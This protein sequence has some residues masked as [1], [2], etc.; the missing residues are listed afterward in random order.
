M[1]VKKLLFASVGCVLVAAT[2]EPH[3]SPAAFDMTREIVIEG[4][5]VELEWKNPHIYLTLETTGAD[6]VVRRQEAE[7]APVGSVQTYGVTRAHL[8]PGTPIVLRANPSRREG[9]I[10]RAL[11]FA[12]SDGSVRMLDAIGSRS[13]STL[14][15]TV[16]AERLVSKWVLPPA[17]FLSRVLAP[18]PLTEAAQ[19]ARAQAM[20]VPDAETLCG[21]EIPPP[22]LGPTLY[23]IEVSD[24]AVVIR[25]D[26]EG[27]AGRRISLVE[28]AHPAD[29]QPS[30]KGHSIGRWEGETLVVDTAGFAPQVSGRGLPL[31]PA[32]RL[33]ERFSLTED[34]LHLV[35]AVT[36]EDP[37]NFLEPVAYSMQ[38]D[39]RPELEFSG[40]ECDPEIDTRNLQDR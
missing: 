26:G 31:G 23:G 1:F 38:W 34:R 2:A 17:A 25:A 22:H 13:V 14:A 11:S 36:I 16:P 18:L 24:E 21:K 20:Q 33:A 12:A 32:T 35:Y 5:V 10:I 39:H 8:E 40:L 15:P 7:A 4:T 30:V 6:G 27:D 9:G 37:D 29:R 19:A 28:T 3:H